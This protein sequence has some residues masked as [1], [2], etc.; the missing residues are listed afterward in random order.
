MM[1][2][3]LT[4]TLALSFALPV[5]AADDQAPLAQAYEQ[6]VKSTVTNLEDLRLGCYVDTPRFDVP[7]A[8]FCG[9]QGT[10]SDDATVVFQV[11]DASGNPVYSLPS[12]IETEWY[13]PCDW[14]TNVQCVLTDQPSGTFRQDA[15]LINT[16]T[17]NGEVKIGARVSIFPWEPG[18]PGGFRF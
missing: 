18:F 3:L 5:F 16:N 11:L 4:A 10:Y 17:G 13:L 7:R 6:D 14:G 9:A 15:V 1:K 12:H 2:N 8:D